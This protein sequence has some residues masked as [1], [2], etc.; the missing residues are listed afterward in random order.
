MDA[1]LALPVYVRD[2]VAQT[3]Q[4]RD[5]ALAFVTAQ[6]A[7]HGGDVKAAWADFA[8]VLVNVKEFVFLQ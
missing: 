2:K 6:T 3:T 8:H 1:A 4:E 7:A 5:A